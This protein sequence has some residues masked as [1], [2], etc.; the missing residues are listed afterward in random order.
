MKEIGILSGRQ[1]SIRL[2]W[3]QTP[4][5]TIGSIRQAKRKE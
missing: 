5:L 1:D 3:S 2:Q 4:H